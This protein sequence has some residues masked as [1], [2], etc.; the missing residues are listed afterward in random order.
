MWSG[1]DRFPLLNLNQFDRF[2]K[3][4]LTNFKW[5]DFQYNYLPKSQ[6]IMETMIENS[7]I[8]DLK[9]PFR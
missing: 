1:I 4:Q 3:E 9:I 8:A 7:E 6:Y 2:I 5:Y